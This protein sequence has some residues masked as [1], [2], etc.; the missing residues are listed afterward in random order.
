MCA[1]AL[2]KTFHVENEAE[3]ETA[4]AVVEELLVNEIFET[5]ES[6]LGV[7]WFQFDAYMQKNGEIREE[8]ARARTEK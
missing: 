8:S 7:V 5:R 2:A 4:D 6:Y 3:A 1:T